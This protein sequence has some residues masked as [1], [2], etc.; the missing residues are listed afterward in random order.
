MGA[1]A[2]AARRALHGDRAGPARSWCFRETTG[3]LQPRWLRQRHARPARPTRD[4]DG[5]GRRAQF[6]R[7]SGHAV[8]LP[9][10]RAHRTPRSRGY[11]GSRAG[12]EHLAACPDTADGARRV[13][14]ESLHADPAAPA[15]A[16]GGHCCGCASTHR[17]RSRRGTD[18]LYGATESGSPRRLP[19][20]SAPRHGLA[21]AVGHDA[22]SFIP[23][24]RD[25]HPH[26][27]GRTGFRRTRQPRGLGEPGDAALAAGADARRRAFPAPR[28]PRGLQPVGG[29]VRGRHRTE[30][31]GRRAMAVPAALPDHRGHSLAE[32]HSS[33]YACATFGLTCPAGPATL[34]TAQ[35]SDNSTVGPSRGDDSEPR[36]GGIEQ[37]EQ[38]LQRT[39]VT[40]ALDTRWV[41][42]G[43][44]AK[45]PGLGERERELCVAFSAIYSAR[46]WGNRKFISAGASVPGVSWNSMTTPSTVSRCPV[47]VTS[48][49][50]GIKEMVPVDVVWPKPAPIWPLAALG[51]SAPYM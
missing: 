29:G 11:R 20:R 21:R 2:P 28:A 31:V 51:S 36:V 3:R 44:Q 46:R 22:R 15:H 12:G 7:R 45:Q 40:A 8:R 41:L 24:S 47:R 17:R 39:W 23:D 49:V 38:P 5:D 16:C 27:L 43:E 9:V 19:A 34:A 50:G 25:A 18:G 1:G 42:P 48:M 4:R 6:R 13:D 14:P 37:R 30:H 32:A 35:E 26:R 33:G 10:P